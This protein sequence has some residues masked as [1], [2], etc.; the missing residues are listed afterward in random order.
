MP[1]HLL[2]HLEEIFPKRMSSMFLLIFKIILEAFNLKEMKKIKIKSNSWN[3][4]IFGTCFTYFFILEKFSPKEWTANVASRQPASKSQAN[5]HRLS[6]T[7]QSTMVNWV[8]I[9]QIILSLLTLKY[10]M[11]VFHRTGTW[12]GHY[13]GENWDPFIIYLGTIH[14]RYQKIWNLNQT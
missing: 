14:L 1:L 13:L 2:L 4:A 7:Q 6:G 3:S 5:L 12:A 9:V 10:Q 8:K 11:V